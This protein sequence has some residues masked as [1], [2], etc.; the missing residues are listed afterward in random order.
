MLFFPGLISL[1]R[2][3]RRTHGG[4]A[5][6]DALLALRLADKPIAI[7]Q[8]L[9]DYGLVVMRQHL[10]ALQILSHNGLRALQLRGRREMKLGQQLFNALADPNLVYLLLMAGI[11]VFRPEGLFP[12]ASR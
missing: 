2:G 6:I 3:I 1:K 11:L 12:A 8:Y 4:K 9:E 5:I 7:A 10:D